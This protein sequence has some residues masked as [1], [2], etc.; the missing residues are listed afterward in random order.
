MD[1]DGNQL[2]LVVHTTEGDFSDPASRQWQPL[3]TSISTEAG[4][5]VNRREK[6]IY[7]TASGKVLRS[8]DPGAP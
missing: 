5:I 7:E 2:M 4:E 3:M 6:G 1:A 8:D